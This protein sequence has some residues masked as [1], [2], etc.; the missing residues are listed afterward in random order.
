MRAR[1][2]AAHSMPTRSLVLQLAAHFAGLTFRAVPRRARFPLALRAAKA[3]APGIARTAFYRGRPWLHDAPR[4]E[5]LRLMVRAMTRLGVRF[6]PTMVVTGAELIPDGAALFAA[7]HMSLN[8]LMPRWLHDR[9]DAVTILT[10][11]P[12]PGVTIMGSD[13]PLDAVDTDTRVFLRAR[14]RLAKG[15]KVLMMPE[16][17]KPFRGAIEVAA[18]RGRAYVSPAIFRLAERLRVPML[19]LSTHFD[20]RDVQVT[21]ARP[22]SPDAATMTAEFCDFFVA[23]TRRTVG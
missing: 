4:D 19:F 16:A 8:L 3:A 5:S 2:S 6:D 22:T 11:R 23:E 17:S 10:W 1:G 15:R 21:L 14:S 13:V 12:E 18:P 9:G 20:G 7:G